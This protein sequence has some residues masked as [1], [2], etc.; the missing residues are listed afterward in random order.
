[1]ASSSGQSAGAARLLQNQL[2]EIQKADDLPGISVGLVNDSNIF[3][4]EVVLMINDETKYYGGMCCSPCMSFGKTPTIPLPL[5]LSVSTI[6]NAFT[7]SRKTS[8]TELTWHLSRSLF[9]RPPLLPARIPH[10]AA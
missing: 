4:W 6:I 2:R 5:F 1:M 9:S 10:P 3:E 8:R 7:E